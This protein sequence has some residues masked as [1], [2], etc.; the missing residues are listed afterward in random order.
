MEYVDIVFAHRY[1]VDSPMEETCRAFNSVINAG[2]AFYWGTS[3]WS[4]A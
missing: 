2:L 3:D 4:A 1:D